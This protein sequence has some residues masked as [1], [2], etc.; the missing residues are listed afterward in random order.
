MLSECRALVPPA[1]PLDPGPWAPACVWVKFGQCVEG[2]VMVEKHVVLGEAQLSAADGPSPITLHTLHTVGPPHR[3]AQGRAGS[4]VQEPQGGQEGKW[5][6]AQHSTLPKG[7]D[8]KVG[9]GDKVA[10]RAGVTGD[11]GCRGQTFPGVEQE[12]RGRAAV[13]VGGGLAGG[14]GARTHIHAGHEQRP[15]GCAQLPRTSS[16]KDTPKRTAEV[17]GL[18]TTG[19]VLPP[20][21]AGGCHGR[22]VGWG[23]GPELPPPKATLL[24]SHVCV[25]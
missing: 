3:G 16:S 12:G 17:L 23:H 4:E 8:W 19:G 1:L 21:G 2:L 24:W 20:S 18:W 11:R 6:R 10:P 25:T 22:G 7:G 14:G 15:P 9:R 5:D 13:V